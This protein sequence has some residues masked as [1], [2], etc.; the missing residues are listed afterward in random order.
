MARGEG[1]LFLMWF[2]GYTAY[3][4]LESQEKGHQRTLPEVMRF[5]VGPLTSLTLA[6]G[7][8]RH[9]RRVDS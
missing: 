5:F 1:G 6:I 4:I 8:V 7:V 2:V 3:L 9:F